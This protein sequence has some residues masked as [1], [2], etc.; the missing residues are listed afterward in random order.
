MQPVALP[1]TVSARSLHR[2]SGEGVVVS[3]RREQIFLRETL[4]G[5]RKHGDAELQ[6]FRSDFDQIIPSTSLLR[7]SSRL[8]P[9]VPTT[10]E[11]LG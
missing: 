11:R 7:K 8:T 5:L 1:S 10:N 9:P 4:R 2:G 6:L 3:Y